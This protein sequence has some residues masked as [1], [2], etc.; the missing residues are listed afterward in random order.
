MTEQLPNRNDKIYKEIESFKDYEFTNCVAFEMAIRNEIVLNT[1]DYLLH[2]YDYYENLEYIPFRACTDEDTEIDSKKIFKYRYRKKL[3]SLVNSYYIDFDSVK[4]YLNM[5][6]N[7]IDNTKLKRITNI[8][9][10]KI[11]TLMTIETESNI[12]LDNIS[13]NKAFN[14]FSRPNLI[15]PQDK[16]KPLPD[17]NF[18]LPKKE[19][20]KY[21][22]ILKDEYDKEF[23]S[24]NSYSELNYGEITSK[25][26]DKYSAKNPTSTV[27]ADWFFIYDY[28]KYEKQ[29]EK[30]DK[31]IFID[32]EME[33]QIDYKEDMIRKI[34]DK[35]KFF[36]EELGY[37]KLISGT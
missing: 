37:I 8:K 2:Y 27:Y 22:K 34:R 28:W 31:D 5:L 18:N 6:V 29:N 1:L 3:D 25:F 15:V 24:I 30:T 23:L 17:I 20:L 4:L 14:K 9:S 32:L 35:M 7:K 16:K 33:N 19:L 11:L 12:H 36:I 10:Y 26:E 13:I 21:I